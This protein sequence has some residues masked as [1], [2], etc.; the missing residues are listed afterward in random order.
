MKKVGILIFGG[1]IGLLFGF[2]FF[3][4][5]EFLLMF[6]LLGGL[7]GYLFYLFIESI[8]WKKERFLLKLKLKSLMMVGIRVLPMFLIPFFAGWGILIL[9]L[10]LILGEVNLAVLTSLLFNSVIPAELAGLIT[11]IIIMPEE[12]E[13]LEEDYE[14]FKKADPLAYCRRICQW[15][16]RKLFC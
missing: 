16:Q 11:Y 3:F 14:I 1:I 6:P 10:M 13:E 8:I 2:K 5:K 4:S 12:K 15:I 9:L 7:T